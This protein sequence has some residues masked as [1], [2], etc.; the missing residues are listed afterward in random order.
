[1]TDL[2]SN[3]IIFSTNVPEEAQET[4]SKDLALRYSKYVCVVV[5]LFVVV[6]FFCLF[7]WEEG[8][9]KY[10]HFPPFWSH[11]DMWSGKK[12]FLTYSIYFLFFK[13]LSRKIK[14]KV[15]F[16]SLVPYFP[17]LLPYLLH[18]CQSTGHFW[19]TS[20]TKVLWHLSWTPHPN[21]Y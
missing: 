13:V 11:L 3:Y 15:H 16:D 20:P 4:K 17:N 5:F 2:C 12:K 19:T 21:L 1:M 14:N 9:K 18:S 8:G 7:V 6:V 10:F